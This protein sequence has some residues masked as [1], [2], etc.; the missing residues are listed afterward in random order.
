MG[1]LYSSFQQFIGSSSWREFQEYSLINP[2]LS[3][4]YNLAGQLMAVGDGGSVNV[5][6]RERNGGWGQPIVSFQENY[7]IAV[8]FTPLG[9]ELAV[10]THNQLKIY[11]TVM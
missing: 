3:I 9:H 11:R 10:A 4:S 6:R 1:P 8:L 2:V 5:W 7:P